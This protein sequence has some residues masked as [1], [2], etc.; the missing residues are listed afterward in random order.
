M[1]T[2]KT[3]TPIKNRITQSGSF[4]LGRIVQKYRAMH[5]KR[6]W[7]AMALSFL[8]V[9]SCHQSTG[10]SVNVATVQ[11][12][13]S[14]FSKSDMMRYAYL[15]QAALAENPDL[16]TQMDE[17]KIRLV[18]AQPDLLRKDG[19]TQSWQYRAGK[20]V[21]DV[22]MTNGQPDVVHYEF[23]SADALDESEPERW[24]CLQS[25]YQTRRAAIE[26]A[27]EDVYADSRKSDTAG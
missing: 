20:C 26:K 9:G 11:K 3:I 18:L 10:A 19:G 14:E 15:L 25:L 2:S 16:F 21:L 13:L 7:G 27:F 5:F 17:R 23:R 8:L 24:G 1:F 4:I 12:S 6:I 22:F